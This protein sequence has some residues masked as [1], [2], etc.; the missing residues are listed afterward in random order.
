MDEGLKVGDR[1][2]AG[3]ESERDMG[4][5]LEV[6]GDAALVKWDRWGGPVWVGLEILHSLELS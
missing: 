5:V 2:E 3:T 4:T 6:T 1:V